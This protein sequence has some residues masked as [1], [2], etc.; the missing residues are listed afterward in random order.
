MSARLAAIGLS[1]FCLDLHDKSSKPAGVRAQILQA[2]DLA[3][4][5]DEQGFTVQRQD[6]AASA[7]ALDLYARRLHEKNSAG[8]SFYSARTQALAL[9]RRRRRCRSPSTRSPASPPT[10]PRTCGTC[11]GGSTRPPTWPSR[12]AHH[13]WG[14]VRRPGVAVDDL[15]AAVRRADTAAQRLAQAPGA[16]GAALDAASSPEDVAAAA[17][18][19]DRPRGRSARPRRG[20]HPLLVGPARPV[21]AGAGLVHR[22]RPPGPRPG[23]PDGAE[24]A[25]GPDPGRSRCRGRLRVLRPQEADRRRVRAAGAVPVG[26][27]ETQGGAAAG[28][29]VAGDPQPCRSAVTGRVPPARPARPGLVESVGPGHAAAAA[30]ADRLAAVDRER[31]RPGEGVPPTR[32]R[33]RCGRSSTPT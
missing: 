33:P 23:R 21:R 32:T 22:V 7:R 14:F 15:K 4:V 13:P 30:G 1:P 26:S 29:R 19:P 10:S 20:A 31:D 2:L 16:L 9:G 24:P 12:V 25:A 28:R 5:T 3:P 11:S 18:R 6:L 8:L 27:P 17:R